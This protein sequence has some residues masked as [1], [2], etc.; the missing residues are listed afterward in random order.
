MPHLDFFTKNVKNW[1]RTWLHPLF[2][3]VQ[4]LVDA[5]KTG[6]FLWRE[7]VA[8]AAQ[9]FAWRTASFFQARHERVQW[10]SGAN[11]KIMPHHDYY[12]S[13]AHLQPSTK[14]IIMEGGLRTRAAFADAW[15]ILGFLFETPYYSFTCTLGCLISNFHVPWNYTYLTFKVLGILQSS[16]PCTLGYNWGS[17]LTPYQFNS[18]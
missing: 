5:S 10:P 14:I 6:N 12:Y 13:A 15:K 3:T 2:P 7:T 4:L 8:A 17:I 18:E 16:F 1:I 11:L 9:G